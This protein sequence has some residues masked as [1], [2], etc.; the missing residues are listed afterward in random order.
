MP[1]L[2][3]VL[4]LVLDRIAKNHA[5]TWRDRVRIES[6]SRAYQK[7]MQAPARW[8]TV[9]DAQREGKISMHVASRLAVKAGPHLHAIRFAQEEHSA[10]ID[11][12]VT[13]AFIARHSPNVVRIVLPTNREVSF[14]VLRTFHDLFPPQTRLDANFVPSEAGKQNGDANDWHLMSVVP[15]NRF[16]L[17]TSVYATALS[18]EDAEITKAAAATYKSM[19]ITFET[20][21]D[22]VPALSKLV[23]LKEVTFLM[24]VPQMVQGLFPTLC[25]AK[26]LSLHAVQDCWSH[27]SITRWPRLAVVDLHIRHCN[28]VSQLQFATQCPTV[29]K[30][31][32]QWPLATPIFNTNQLSAELVRLRIAGVHLT[33]VDLQVCSVACRQRTLLQIFYDSGCVNHVKIESSVVDMDTYRWL[34]GHNYDFNDICVTFARGECECCIRRAVEDARVS[35]VA[36]E[37]D[38]YFNRE[39]DADEPLDDDAD[40]GDSDDDYDSDKENIF[41]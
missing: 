6:L 41:D 36:A 33:L 13:L 10:A 14:N 35:R 40:E 4:D 17:E 24:H 16:R 27:D 3:D 39:F 15:E 34:D 22:H 18:R 11:F 5:L 38:M 20:A 28:L 21:H 26:Q 37:V 8:P 9:L 7:C 23:S 19:A 12:E 25:H 2:L 31:T 30:V 32:V 1:L 29:R